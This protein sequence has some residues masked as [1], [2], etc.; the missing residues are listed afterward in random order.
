MFPSLVSCTTIDWFNEWPAEALLE[1]A[2]KFMQ[3][4]DVG[5]EQM[6]HLVSQQFVD[7]HT[8]VGKMNVRMLNE[9]KRYNYVTPTNF[10]ELV[11][12]YKVLLEEKRRELMSAASKLRNG[13]HKL[14][15]GRKQVEAMSREL[16]IKQVEVERNQEE[17]DALLKVIVVEKA[18]ADKQENEVS[19]DAAKIE[20][21]KVEA[22]KIAAEMQEQL[23]EALPQLRE[24]EKLLG[25]LNRGDMVEV[26]SYTRVPLEVELVL[27]AVMVLLG[28]PATV[29]EAKRRMADPSFISQL[30]SY[31]KDHMSLAVLGKIGK[32]TSMKEF[33]PEVR[34]LVSLRCNEWLCFFR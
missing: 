19:Q 31:D 34:L 11:K 30:T 25:T 28:K 21:E 1:V 22:E 17:C 12:G 14:E 3:E 15:E 10:L 2:V 8:S 33:Q 29:D 27:K 5:G 16:A 32:Y 20:K 13:L 9:I 23:E 18:D 4:V 6:Q 24:A 7:V 26:R